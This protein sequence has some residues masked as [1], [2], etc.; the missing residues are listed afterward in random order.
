[1]LKAERLTVYSMVLILLVSMSCSRKYSGGNKIPVKMKVSTVERAYVCL[2]EDSLALKAYYI[3]GRLLREGHLGLA[4]KFYLLA[5]SCDSSFCDAMDELGVVYRR[6]GKLDSAVYW[7]KKSIELSGEINT[8]PH[9]NLAVVYS[10][11]EKLDDALLEYR[12]VI[13]IAPE[14]GEG[15]FGVGKILLFK[16]QIK[17]AV[18][19]LKRAE[20]LYRESDPELVKDPRYFL[21]VAYFRMGKYELGREYLESVYEE[22]KDMSSINYYLGMYYLIRGNNENL[23]RKY[24]RKARELGAELSP[25]L[26]KFLDQ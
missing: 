5:I 25:E 20:K 24:L 21:G 6:E 7:Y 12:K 18:R 13:E 1:M 26:N 19:H 11:Q 8:V 16:G 15:Y 2:S 14:S 9:I 3:G 17:E 4:K 10:I 22:L 23:A